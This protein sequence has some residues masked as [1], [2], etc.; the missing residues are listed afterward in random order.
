MREE[1]EIEAREGRLEEIKWRIFK[2]GGGGGG[3]GNE[4]GGS[5][6]DDITNVD[7]C[8]PCMSFLPPRPSPWSKPLRG[9]ASSL[10]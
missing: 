7:S 3:E 4:L 6:A 10:W 5:S 8:R 2:A 1:G 9:A